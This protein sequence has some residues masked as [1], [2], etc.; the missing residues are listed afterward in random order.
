MRVLDVRDDDPD[1][2][3]GLEAEV[4]RQPVG[5][6]R[7]GAVPL[8]TRETVAGETPA[9]SAISAML[10][11]LFEIDFILKWISAYSRSEFV[12]IRTWVRASAG[13]GCLP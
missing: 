9:F 3:G 7:T 12:S 1:R 6:G 13:G 8:S 11:L 4:A 10:D 2:L 5:S